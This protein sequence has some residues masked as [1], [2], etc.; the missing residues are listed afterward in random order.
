M[1]GRDTI[2]RIRSRINLV[3]LV[4]ES[5]KL[6]RRGRSHVGLCPFHQEKSPSF[7]VS[8]T[9]FHCF[10]CKQSGD[11]FKFVELTE[12]L[13]F[14]ESLRKLAEKAG[15]PLEDERSDHDRAAETRA[16][17]A[18]DDL[19]A[20]N[21]MAAGYFERM[22]V[23]H[24]HA[25]FARDE[26]AR[27]GLG[28]DGDAKA[29]LQ[30][31]KVGYA[32]HGW[33]GLAT[34][35]KHNGV[36]PAHAE[37]LG[38][39]APRNNGPG[40]YDAFRHRLM[41][42][43][44][45][46]QGRV[47]AFSGRALADPPEDA[48]RAA[49]RAQHGPPPKYVNSRESQIYSKGSTLFGLFQARNAIRTKNEAIVVE[50]NFD[51]IAMHARGIEHVVAPMGT[52]FTEDQ[53]RLLRRFAQAVVLLFDADAAGRKATVAARDTCKTVGLAARVARMPQ[54]KDPDEFLQAKGAPAMN[55]VLKASRALDEVLIDDLC[56]P[57]GEGADLTAKQ[58]AL[59]KVRPILED[60][61]ITL[62]D[63]LAKRV[64]GRLGLETETLWRL[65]RGA[66]PDVDHDSS[67]G[68]GGGGGAE[69]VTSGSSLDGRSRG[70]EKSRGDL[71]QERL[72]RAIVEILLVCPELLEDPQVHELE[73]WLGLVTGDWTFAVVE[74]RKEMRNSR[75]EN[76]SPDLASVLAQLPEAIQ[77]AAA[78]KLA[79]P[80]LETTYTSSETGQ[81]SKKLSAVVLSSTA[82]GRP[83]PLLARRVIRET[84]VK[85]EKAVATARYRE[86][87][88]E[89]D[90]AEQSGDFTRAS[91]LLA[92]KQRLTVAIR[93]ATEVLRNE[94][95][96]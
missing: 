89:I 83:D 30:S 5:V 1:I 17:K 24:P 43:I 2:D 46:V 7:S 74:L 4:A 19:Y 3:A 78:A 14:G 73:P 79:D 31:F 71:E 65:I 94:R 13:S 50:G 33:D 72:S 96:N 25:H 6:Q 36:S 10:G 11:C 49:S 54:G 57:V 18:K 41:V 26:L 81:D 8:D 29:C 38:L 48:A 42:S 12:G 87:E 23:E 85:L 16:K 34:F 84:G 62:R 93:K 88:R 45:D 40:Y 58:A 59:Q 68:R 92:E 91:E 70:P 37:Q 28:Y 67:G 47:V 60:Q 66:R 53:A 20:I 44:L 80:V 76:R 69:R 56:E 35:L 64:A 27:R 75:L 90:R 77:E 39:L 51:L 9:F 55:D 86:I 61:E 22:L 63:H 52:A 95:P 21:L 15:V 32:P 82:D